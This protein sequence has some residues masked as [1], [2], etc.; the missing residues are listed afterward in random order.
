MSAV[1]PPPQKK[2]TPSVSKIV[3]TSGKF[4]EP[5]IPSKDKNVVEEESRFKGS[6]LRNPSMHAEGSESPTEA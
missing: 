1:H 5:I 6:E 2:A 4:S 3:K